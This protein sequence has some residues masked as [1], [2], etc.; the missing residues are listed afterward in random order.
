[1]KR[2]KMAIVAVARKLAMRLR[3]I[4]L[5]GEPYQVGLIECQ[6]A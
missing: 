6:A 1:M 3:S 2:K 5:S 4:L